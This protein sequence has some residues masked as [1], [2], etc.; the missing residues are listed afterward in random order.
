LA[1]EIA[2]CRAALGDSAVSVRTGFALHIL[3]RC[4]ISSLQVSQ[5]TGSDILYRFC[6]APPP[7]SAEFVLLFGFSIHYCRV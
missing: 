1:E 2:L 3:N 4:L 6:L 5:G 7:L